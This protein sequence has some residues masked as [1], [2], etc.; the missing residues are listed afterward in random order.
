MEEW[1][2][3]FLM[4]TLSF[5]LFTST[6]AISCVFPYSKQNDITKEII[7]ITP[8]HS[9]IAICEYHTLFPPFASVLVRL[10]WVGVDT[11]VQEPRSTDKTNDSKDSFDCHG[12]LRNCSLLVVGIEP[13]QYTHHVEEVRC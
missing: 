13:V 5:G 10:D 1:R 3:P 9:T 6:V 7:L 2:P 8:A 11:K 12:L 4:N